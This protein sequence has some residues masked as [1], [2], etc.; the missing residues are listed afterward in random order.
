[1]A[2]EVTIK[3]LF[4]IDGRLDLK[5]WKSL[6]TNYFQGNP[7]IYE[8]FGLKKPEVAKIQ[9]PNTLSICEKYVPYS[10]GKGDG[11][12]ML[13]S[14]HTKLEHQPKD[15][16]ICAFDNVS[17]KDGTGQKA[18]EYFTV[19]LV[20]ALKRRK[21]ELEIPKDCLLLV[22]EDYYVNLPCI[23]HSD[24]NSQ[25]LLRGTIDGITLL[26]SKLVEKGIE[27]VLSI[28][29]AWNMED[30]MT[31]LA[32]IGHSKDLYDWLK[33]CTNVPTDRKSFKIWLE[34]TAA[35]IKASGQHNS[36][37]VLSEIVCDDGVLYF[38]RRLVQIDASISFPDKSDPL[39]MELGIK[40][41]DSDLAE[42]IE[43]K[44]LYATPTFLLKKMTCSNS[45]EDYTTC[46]H[47]VI[48]DTGVSQTLEKF[49]FLSHHW[50]DRPKPIVIQ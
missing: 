11:F 7:Q 37:P 26:L 14:Y 13:V 19:E 39:K 3:K 45:N 4:R 8:Y 1:M 10:I 20:K 6:V 27:L 49:E 24:T 46:N 36:C 47:S 16:F 9:D 34:D 28:N 23:F 33:T 48:L 32:I 44:S 40:K 15:R 17:T 29:L 22:P 50:T 2:G 18:I 41:E 25:D 21:I 42:A 43:N 38:K 12:R 35:Y 5:D 30:K 31:V